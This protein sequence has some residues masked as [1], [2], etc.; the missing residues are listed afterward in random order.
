MWRWWAIGLVACGADAGTAGRVETDRGVCEPGV[1]SALPS[2]AD[3]EAAARSDAEQQRA[4]RVQV[5]WCAQDGVRA[6]YARLSDEQGQ[7]T[8]WFDE[9]GR[10]IGLVVTQG[11]VCTEALLPGEPGPLPSCTDPEEVWLG[12]EDRPL[13]GAEAV[14][15]P[16]VADGEVCGEQL[17]LTGEHRGFKRSEAFLMLQEPYLNVRF[18]D[19]D[20]DGAEELLV[21]VTDL[22]V[23]VDL[24]REELV[25]SYWSESSLLEIADVD[26]DGVHD[27][28]WAGASGLW[29]VAGPLAQRRPEEPPDPLPLPDFERSPLHVVT[30]LGELDGQPG[31]E[32]VL[33]SLLEVGADLTVF[34][35]AAPTDQ[36]VLARLRSVGGVE[37]PMRATLARD[38]T[39]DGVL[40]LLMVPTRWETAEAE[41]AAEAVLYRGPLSGE[42]QGQ[43]VLSGVE[44]VRPL[45]D[46][47][48]DGDDDLAVRVDGGWYV[49]MGPFGGGVIELNAAELGRRWGA[50][51]TPVRAAGVRA[52]V[53][54]I[55]VERTRSCWTTGP[56][57][58]PLTLQH[59]G[60]VWVPLPLPDEVVL[61]AGVRVP[62]RRDNAQS[63]QIPTR[64]GEPLA[65]L[66][67]DDTAAARA[68]LCVPP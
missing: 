59:H 6:R 23:G 48:L 24:A 39:G 36:S 2:W 53:W 19:L 11:D 9:A 33:G 21:G 37:G 27:A 58:P 62:D 34:S 16:A 66:L 7:Y 41:E 49:V 42:V 22:A 44:R 67:V 4:C 40:D 46:V 1:V 65:V 14:Y 10:G 45:G 52:V 60:T 64:A 15:E 30:N 12:C 47:D 55:E 35:P 17:V 25:W 31:D 8:S 54:P 50:A 26:G 13:C 56:E 57:R 5:G 51:P 63:T 18:V 32:L 68:D 20:G 38:Y 3:Y 61:P 28:V 43:V 29:W